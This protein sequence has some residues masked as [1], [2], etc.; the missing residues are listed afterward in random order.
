MKIASVKF[1]YGIG[2]L[3]KPVHIITLSRGQHLDLVTIP[4]VADTP[5]SSTLEVLPVQSFQDNAAL[6]YMVTVPSA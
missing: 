3:V 2:L 4:R 5:H 6:I 1:E